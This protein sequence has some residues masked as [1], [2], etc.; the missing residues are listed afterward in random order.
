MVKSISSFIVD[1]KYDLTS[2]RAEKEH[3]AVADA[4][5]TVKAIFI[6][7]MTSSKAP[8]V[9]DNTLIASTMLNTVTLLALSMVLARVSCGQSFS[10]S[11]LYSVANGLMTLL[12]WKV[13]L[14]GLQAPMPNIDS[15]IYKPVFQFS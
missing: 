5:G 13:A 3:S 12:S 14:P 6:S 4:T 7:F 15:M 9:C 11:N 8:L 1:R 10:K 2:L